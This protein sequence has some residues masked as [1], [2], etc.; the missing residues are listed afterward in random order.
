MKRV[1]LIFCM[2]LTVASGMAQSPY[3]V[4]TKASKSTGEVT[5]S[6]DAD[7]VMNFLASNFKRRSLCDWEVGMKFMVIPEKYDLVVCTF[8]DAK[9]NYEVNNGNLRH[10]I[11][12][13]KGHTKDNNGSVRL[14]FVCQDDNKEY[15]FKIPSGSF[16]DYCY[17]MTGVRTLA[18][19][20]DVDKARELLMGETL[21]TKAQQYMIDTENGGQQEIFVGNNTEVKVVA[22]GVGTRSFPVKIIV[23]DR[24]GNQFYQNVAMSRTNCGLRDDEFMLDKAKNTFWGSFNFYD[25]NVSAAS[26]SQ[27]IGQLVYTKNATKMVGPTGETVSIARLTQFSI[28]KIEPKPM[29]DFVTLWLKNAQNGFQYAKTVKLEKGEGDDA[30]GNEE[31][32][33]DYW[34][35]EGNVGKGISDDNLEL[36]RKGRLAK[37]FTAKEVKLALGEP[38]KVLTSKEGFVSWYY[39]NGHVVKFD[40]SGKM[41]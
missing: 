36:I 8:Y 7:G 30:K 40:R 39:K 5:V 26:Y 9:T 6:E 37:G 25:P 22:I 11:M 33:F 3:I 21:I 15:Y 41:M 17:K 20:G 28:K 4:K 29:T 1:F 35:E 18:Y 31:D 2:A 27:Y 10:K 23:E 12:V 38:E 24:H 13:Y 19:L 14:N 16:D 34:F 32:Y